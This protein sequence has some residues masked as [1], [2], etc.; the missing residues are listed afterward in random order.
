MRYEIVID[1]GETPNKCTIAP[2]AYRP[3]FTLIRARGDVI[4]PRLT[5]PLLLHHEGPCITGF[6]RKG[7]VVD[8][9]AAIDCVWRRLGVLVR[10]IPKPLPVLVSIP[11]GFAT[12]YPRRS[13]RH[14]DPSGGLATI[15]AIFIAAAL[16]GHWDRS[17]LAEYY[18]AP[19]FIEK[20]RARFLELGVMQASLEEG[21][22]EHQARHREV[23]HEPRDV[24]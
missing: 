24:H 3:D 7:P 9:I 18:F 1:P 16:L 23:D 8:G 5:S 21:A 10:R 22:F 2:L 6:R 4:L 14:V 15:E 11:E 19:V 12:A 17:L 20:N 13:I